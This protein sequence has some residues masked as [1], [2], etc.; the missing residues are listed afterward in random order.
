[1]SLASMRGHLTADL[2]KNSDYTPSSSCWI[3]VSCKTSKLRC[4]QHVQSG[5]KY[6]GEIAIYRGRKTD[7][8][9][10]LILILSLRSW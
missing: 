9:H 2:K 7:E 6:I 8:L 10:S 4:A 3:S 5:D 1:M